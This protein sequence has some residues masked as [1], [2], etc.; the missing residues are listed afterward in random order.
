MKVSNFRE[1]EVW[2][3]A[4]NLAREIYQLTARFPVEE[5]YGLVS[6]LQRAAVS[7]PSNIAEG[8]C[9][10]STREYARFVSIAR[11]SCAELETQLILS[12]QV[13]LVDK[14]AIDELL[15]LCERVGRM[16]LNLQRALIAKIHSPT[17]VSPR[18][19]VP[20]PE[21]R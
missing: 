8:N 10:G 3:L 5:R 6:Q 14:S 9:R 13:K 1:L 21:S 4:M 15:V 7:I 18:S 12:A 11:G 19:P 16:L 2:R 17:G 20:S